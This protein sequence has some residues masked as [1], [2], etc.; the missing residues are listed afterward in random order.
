MSGQDELLI[1][2]TAPPAALGGKRAFALLLPLPRSEAEIG[3]ALLWVVPTR[4]W[5]DIEMTWS[6]LARRMRGTP[7]D[8]RDWNSRTS[9]RL[10]PDRLAVPGREQDVIVAGQQ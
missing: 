5:I 10:E 9:V 2:E 3:L 8:V 4:C 7:V 6:P 1:V